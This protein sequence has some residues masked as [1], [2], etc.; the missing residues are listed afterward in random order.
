MTAQA[1]LRVLVVDDDAAVRQ[2]VADMLTAQGHAVHAVALPSEA[3]TVAEEATQ[4]FEL[5]VTDVILPQMTGLELARRLAE[6]WPELHV[7]YTSG[8]ANASIM[9]PDA[10]VPGSTFLNK[11]FM[12][13][14]LASAAQH[15]VAA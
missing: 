12:S 7:V 4:P 5:L 11:P 6:H 3:L 9:T 8:Y 10:V 14:Q 13:S 1:Q 15:A 2:S